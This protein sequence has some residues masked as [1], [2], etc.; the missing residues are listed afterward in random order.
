MSS[1]SEAA[2]PD[3]EVKMTEL[4]ACALRVDEGVFGELAPLVL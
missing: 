3:G 1:Y 2:R 4:Q